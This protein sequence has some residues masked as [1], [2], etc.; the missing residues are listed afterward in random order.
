[1]AFAVQEI[2]Q[3]QDLLPHLKLGYHIRDSCDD[4]PVSLKNTLLL[5][6]GQPEKGSGSTCLDIHRKVSP[7]IVGD[8]GSGVSMAVLRILGSFHVP[9]VS[10]F[11]S[12]SCLSNQKEFP[13]FM[14]TM[15]SDAFQTKALAR[16]VSHFHWTWVGVI[17]LESDYARFAIQ[18][19]L[20]EAARYNVCAAYVHFLSLPLIK[21]AVV[22][23]VKTMKKSSA[24]VVLSVSGDTEMRVILTECRRQN[25]TD[26][27]W[28]ASE[29]WSTSQSLWT[30]FEDLLRG[31]VGFAIRKG[32]IPGLGM[33]LNSLHPS[34]D[35]ISHFIAEFWEETF[36][37][38]LKGS[39]G[40][41]SGL[42]ELNEV[43]SVYTDVSQ[44]RVTYNVY[45]AV[46]LIAHALH[47]M[48]VCVPG[49][50]PFSNGTCGSLAPVLPW[51]VSRVYCEVN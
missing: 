19:F 25:V 22:E 3:R 49:K 14:R 6:N 27:L 2:N 26:L 38:R 30:D 41:C 11:A 48:S 15:P 46:H 33:Y 10:Y 45:K 50:G 44:L 28:I 17:G 40:S 47:D 13:T 39:R 16:L 18:L 37:C 7:V 34:Q 8:A 5:A 29:A 42:E 4:I 36:N 43:Y 12:C 24:R 1:M 51:Q 23:L 32:D 9:L 31:T 21:D 35:L 20:Q